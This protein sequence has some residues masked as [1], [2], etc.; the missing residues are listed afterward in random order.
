MLHLPASGQLELFIRKHVEKSH[1]VTVVLVALKVVCIS[2]NLTDHMLQTC[3]GGKHAIG[4]L[5]SQL[6]EEE[7]S[8]K[9]AISVQSSVKLMFGKV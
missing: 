1:Q 9:L 3:V 6:E 2:T 8:E 5:S 7:Q 4:T